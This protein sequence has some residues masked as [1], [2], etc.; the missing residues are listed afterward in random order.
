MCTRHTPDV[1][2]VHIT[3]IGFGLYMVNSVT[4]SPDVS[5][6]LPHDS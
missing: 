6:Y 3:G 4:D 2:A 1:V 5:N